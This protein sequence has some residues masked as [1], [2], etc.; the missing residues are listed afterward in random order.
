MPENNF[1]NEKMEAHLLQE[2]CFF[3]LIIDLCHRFF[4]NDYWQEADRYKMKQ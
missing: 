3:Y 4:I 1:K 2:T